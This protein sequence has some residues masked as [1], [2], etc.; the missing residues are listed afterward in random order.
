MFTR[1]LVVFEERVIYSLTADHRD[2]GFVILTH[3]Y[4]LVGCALPVWLTAT[5]FSLI[6]ENHLHFPWNASPGDVTGRVSSLYV[7]S[8]FASCAGIVTLGVSDA[9]VSAHQA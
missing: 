4:L 1:S 9:M 2:E 3:V 7:W 8:A 5:L 6:P